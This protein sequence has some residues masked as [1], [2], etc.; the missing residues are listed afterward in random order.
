MNAVDYAAN[1]Q[2]V[3]RMK[4][5]KLNNAIIGAIIKALAFAWNI[6]QQTSALVSVVVLQRTNLPNIAINAV[7]ALAMIADVSVES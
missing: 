1:I 7:S 4:M 2:I 3:T 5:E 6:C